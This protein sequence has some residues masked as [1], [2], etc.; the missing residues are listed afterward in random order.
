MKHKR[1]MGIM[2]AVLLM[3]LALALA[4]TAACGSGDDD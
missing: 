2:L 1:F 4:F 3:A